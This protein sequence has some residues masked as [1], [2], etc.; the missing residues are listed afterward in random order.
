MARSCTSYECAAADENYEYHIHYY[1]SPTWMFWS[2]CPFR[3]HLHTETD[4]A[5]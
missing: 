1:E 3:E 4:A 2:R 5:L